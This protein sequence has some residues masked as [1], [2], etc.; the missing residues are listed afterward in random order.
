MRLAC[1]LR[2]LAGRDFCCP[3]KSTF[4]KRTLSAHC[5]ERFSLLSSPGP[6]NEKACF[7]FIR[8]PPKKPKYVNQSF[9]ELWLGIMN[10]AQRLFRLADVM[11]I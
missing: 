11:G 3:V 7:R 8:P 2:C 9:V 4:R 5:S 6:D 10:G 1:W